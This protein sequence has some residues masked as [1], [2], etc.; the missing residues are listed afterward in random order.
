MSKQAFSQSAT[1]R[2][3][4]WALLVLALLGLLALSE[5]VLTTPRLLSTDDFVQY[6][7]V[8][9]TNLYGRNPYDPK[10]LAPLQEVAGRADYLPDTATI[11]WNP[12]WTLAFLMPFGLLSYPSARLTWWLLSL[13]AVFVTTNWAWG[14]Y[15]GPAKLRWVAWTLAFGFNAYALCTMG[16]ANLAHSCCSAS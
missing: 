9:R 10:Q 11:A 12:P 14:F 5:A 7:A 6:W 16:W 2:I 4:R 1:Y 13:A 8:G 3:G 15:G